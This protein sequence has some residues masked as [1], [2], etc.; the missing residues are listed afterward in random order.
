MQA[1]DYNVLEICSPV[2]LCAKQTKQ[3]NNNNNKN[4]FPAGSLHL[5]HFPPRV[6]LF[7]VLVFRIDAS[8][9]Q[10]PLWETCW[11]VGGCFYILN[12]LRLQSKPVCLSN[13]FK[14]KVTSQP[15][16]PF[17]SLD[18]GLLIPNNLVISLMLWSKIFNG[19]VPRKLSVLAG[20]FIIITYPV[21][22][23][24]MAK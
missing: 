10:F 22:L 5:I 1:G 8:S 17:R 23:P 15:H 13:A 24:E 14:A 2:L 21:I 11:L 18:C 12:T 16:L 6:W 4:P 20:G 19:Y 9:L 7:G 3:T